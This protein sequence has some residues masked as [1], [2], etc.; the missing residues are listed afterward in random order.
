MENKLT[1]LLGLARRAGKLAFGSDAAQRAVA[2]GSASL[3]LVSADASPGTAEKARRECEK[4]GVSVA[5]LPIGSRAFGEAIG[6]GDTAVAAIT[7]R[8]FARGIKEIC[9]L[10][11]R[12]EDC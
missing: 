1:G 11:K 8:S 12:E 9:R 7:D 4:Y 3:V 10:S 2:G 5:A 6:R